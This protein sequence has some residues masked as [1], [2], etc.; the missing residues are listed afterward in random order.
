MSSQ[1]DSDVQRSDR[2]FAQT[3][4][5]A[6]SL[7]K[8]LQRMWRAVMATVI[9]NEYSWVSKKRFSNT[10]YVPQVR[11]DMGHATKEAHADGGEKHERKQKKL[12]E[13]AAKIMQAETGSVPDSSV[14][15]QKSQ[16]D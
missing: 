5:T 2:P 14:T 15:L 7:S 4:G 11:V 12:H 1:T 13:E 9:P 10:W 3:E 6:L 8:A 16:T